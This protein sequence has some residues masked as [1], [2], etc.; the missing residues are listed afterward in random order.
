MMR[1]PTGMYQPGYSVIHGISA[2]VKLV[3]MILLMAAIVA[4][5]SIPGC[6]AA[7]TATA[8]IVYL[9]QV[10]AATAFASVRR[11]AWFFAIILLMNT[12]FYGA[13]DAWF[14]W[15]IFTPSPRGLIRGANIVLRVVLILV[16]SN[17]L[18]AT[19]AP[20]RLTDGMERLLSPL[21]IVR[22]PTGQI[23]MIVSVAIQFIPA[24]FEEADM[25]RRAQTARGARFDSR[26]YFEKAKAV[27]PLVVPV[28]LA[29]FRR[30]DEL[31]LAMEAR[32]YSTDAVHAEK[33]REKLGAADWSALL[34]STA[35]CALEIVVL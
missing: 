6:L 31:A 14:G 28:F 32:G 35:L 16:L 23:A 13:D 29:A 3:C 33:K 34:V 22:V 30:A 20:L 18:T 27:M 10:S 15:W 24:L 21:R 12:C 5:D 26:S 1:L 17:I 25:I 4:T 8:A 19:T 11:L 9:A 7:I 2:A